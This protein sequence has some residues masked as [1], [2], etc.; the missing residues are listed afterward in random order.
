MREGTSS[1]EPRGRN[2]LDLRRASQLC[3]I[4]SQEPCAIVRGD[5]PTGQERYFMNRSNPASYVRRGFPTGFIA[6]MMCGVLSAAAFGFAIRAAAAPAPGDGERTVSLS[7]KGDGSPEQPP[8][9]PAGKASLASAQ[10]WKQV[11]FAPLA[12]KPAW[13]IGR[14]V[15]ENGQPIPI[16]RA[17]AGGFSGK[18][19]PLFNNQLRGPQQLHETGTAFGHA[20]GSGGQYAIKMMDEA[21]I[22]AVTVLAQFQF[23]NTT[24]GLY[25]WPIDN[26]P[27]G[28]SPGTN[29]EYRAHTSK[30]VV[31]DFVLRL[32][33]IKPGYD[34]A[35]CPDHEGNVPSPKSRYAY[36]GGS[37]FFD[38]SHDSTAD[39]RGGISKVY[40]AGSIVTV[41]LA[42]I[43]N[44]VDGLP[45]HT[46]VRTCPV[47]LTFTLYGIPYAIY[48]A[49][50]T[51]TEP[52]GAIHNLKS[53]DTLPPPQYIS[54]LTGKP[55][56]PSPTGAW[57][58]SVPVHWHPLQDGTNSVIGAVTLYLGE[59]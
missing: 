45:A 6:A 7:T 21:M 8:S 58:P 56:G 13:V 31:R 35:K 24:F 41:T 37:I 49:T 47:D 46:I 14:A 3:L 5:S 18:F 28:L 19:D 25:A 59:P 32:E 12:A 50:A 11:R 2:S 15:L 42:P 40:P 9:T 22:T 29:D 4:M 1:A 26:I 20:D 34:A 52:S 33:G 16:F 53:L 51:I 36:Y 54:P 17:Q 55:V 57:K 30:G 23:D 43:G 10:P 27:D 44:R 39:I 48:T 38:C